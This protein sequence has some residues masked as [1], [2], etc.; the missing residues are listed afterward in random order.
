MDR[1]LWLGITGSSASKWLGRPSEIAD[2]QIIINQKTSFA[3]PVEYQTEK[4]YFCQHYLN[5]ASLDFPD[6]KIPSVA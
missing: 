1:D 6:T 3:K 2:L 4:T 5:L